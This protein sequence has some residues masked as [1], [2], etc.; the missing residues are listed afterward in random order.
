VSIDEERVMNADWVPACVLP[1]VNLLGPIGCDI[2]ALVPASDT[3]V[4][5]IAKCHPIF[6]RFLDSFIDVYGNKFSPAVILVKD[7][8]PTSYLSQE[9][10]A[11][12]R[13][14]VAAST[15]PFNRALEIRKP[16]G[17]MVV[18]SDAF[19][20]FPWMVDK[21]Y[22]SITG[23]TLAFLAGGQNEG[24]VGHSSPRLP[25]LKLGECDVDTPLLSKLLECWK[26]RYEPGTPEWRDI[27][28]F[29][30]L[31]MAYQAAMVPA[32]VE[33]SIYDVGRSIALWV[34]AFE[35]M[36]HPRGKNGKVGFVDVVKLLDTIPSVK[37]EATTT[38]YEIHHRKQ[39]MEVTLASWLYKKL[40]DLRNDFL[41]GN[42]ITADRLIIANADITHKP[43]LYAA[44]LYRL[45]LTSLLGLKFD[46]PIP[47]LCD[48]EA[49]GRHVAEK[50]EFEKHQ[51]Q[52]EAALIAPGKHVAV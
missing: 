36:S 6:A 51:K 8:C 13:D 31:N 38:A 18:F 37:H 35:I 3:R 41:H 15:V 12:F 48:P 17:H 16:M 47:S 33:T 7:K 44:P 29:R 39:Q 49:L 20:I 5:G 50:M 42:P 45:G 34:S 1:N 23:C 32:G 24:L 27:A 28:L 21:K 52:I 40:N 19:E 11:G 14:L 46:K 10:V 2:I 26:R 9:A 43:F 25:R 4:A 30:S 22:S